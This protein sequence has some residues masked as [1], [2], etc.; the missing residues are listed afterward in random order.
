M[1]LRGVGG[2]QAGWK[3]GA[4]LPYGWEGQQS[5]PFLKADVAPSVCE[6]QSP[7]LG[8]GW[9]CAVVMYTTVTMNC[10]RQVVL[11]RL[12][13]WIPGTL[14]LGAG[15]RGYHGTIPWRPGLP[16]ETTLSPSTLVLQVSRPFAISSPG[17]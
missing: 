16:G 6:A 12:A 4:V 10:G 5:R 8:R 1:Q 9:L 7:D 14:L 2:M 11:E 17:E 13:G 15:G 3:E